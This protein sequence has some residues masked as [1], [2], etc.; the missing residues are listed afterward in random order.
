MKPTE[1]SFDISM[2]SVPPNMSLEPDQ[3]KQRYMERKCSRE[4]QRRNDFNRGLE[5]LTEFLYQIDPSLRRSGKVEGVELGESITNRSDLIDVT[6]RSISRLHQDNEEIKTCIDSMCKADPTLRLAWSRRRRKSKDNMDH[7]LAA[8]RAAP[9]SI[10]VIGVEPAT[11]STLP[12]DNSVFSGLLHQQQ[13]LLEL[14]HQLQHAVS[15]GPLPFS[16]QPS[17]LN[18]TECAPAPSTVIMHDFVNNAEHIAH[19]ELPRLFS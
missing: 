6:V 7:S 8:L 3:K 4:K 11:A 19:E 12:C 1:L 18:D 14:Q 16:N 17:F 2:Y 13:R 10:P 5:R 15:A 9:V